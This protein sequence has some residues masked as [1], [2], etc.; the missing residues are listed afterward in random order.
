MSYGKQISQVS[1]TERKLYPQRE[2]KP[3]KARKYTR[4]QEEIDL[5]IALFGYDPVEEQ[6]RADDWRD[7]QSMYADLRMGG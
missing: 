7:E 3:R 4:T 6:A 2:T 1:R 5:C